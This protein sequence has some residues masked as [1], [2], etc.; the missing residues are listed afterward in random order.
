[1]LIW[2]FGDV[3]ES[4]VETLSDISSEGHLEFDKAKVHWF[5][6]IDK[7]DL[8]AECMVKDVSSYRTM[9]INKDLIEFSAGFTDLHTDVYANILTG[10]GYKTNEVKSAIQLVHDIRNAF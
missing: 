6:S 1:M 2:L 3:V 8:P 10:E 7:K 5:L 9:K 4:R